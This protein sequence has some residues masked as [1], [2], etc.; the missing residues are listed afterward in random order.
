MAEELELKLTLTPG[1][2]EAL[3]GSP[4]L[5]SDFERAIQHATYYDTTDLALCK[6]GISL[7][8]RDAEG[9]RI[10]TIKSDQGRSA[11]LFAR[12]ERERPVD[13]DVPDLQDDADVRAIVAGDE[14]VPV[15]EVRNERRRWQLEVEG[16][17]IEVALDQGSVV[18]ADRSSPILECELELKA[19]NAAGL[20][21]LGRRIAAVAP[22]RLAAISKAERGYRLLGALPGRYKAEPIALD[23]DTPV[24][25]AFARIAGA[26][27]RQ[28]L[29]NTDVL[30]TSLSL[31]GKDGVQALHQ[32]RVAL[33]RL[34]AAIR[35]FRP[36]LAADGQ[37]DAIDQGLRE[38]AGVLGEARDLDVML[39]RSEPGQLQRRLRLA[40]TAAYRRVSI[41]LEAETTRALMLDLAEW[42]ARGPWSEMPELQPLRET[43]CAALAADALIHFRR[44]VRKAGRR[45]AKI[46]DEKR[47]ELRKN[48]KKLRY[49]AEFFAALQADTPRAKHHQRFVDALEV[50]Q[51]RLGALND[52]ATTPHVLARLGLS[53]DPQATTLLSGA[54]KGRLLGTA[55]EALRDLSDAKRFW[56]DG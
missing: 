2:A 15:F 51:D 26:C 14:L 54:G 17:Q 29:L 49:T 35:I 53:D 9:Q 36:L 27:L 4:L 34:R 45:V 48:A 7:R 19:G 18:V 31:P 28:Y 3:M 41:E 5:A 8:I 16:A 33:R 30:V 1:A 38:L 22:V 25:D 56:D 39:E 43:P 37:T 46:D 50:V 21:A 10:Q 6:T 55:A 32:A 12:L 13:G 23:S 42:I 24:G 44:K 40:R 52:H 20:F 11:G 47:H